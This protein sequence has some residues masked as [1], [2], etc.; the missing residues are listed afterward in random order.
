MERQEV[1]TTGQGTRG[2]GMPEH[3]RVDMLLGEGRQHAGDQ[4]PQYARTHRPTRP[5]EEHVIFLE[6]TEARE[7]AVECGARHQRH[8]TKV[9]SMRF[10]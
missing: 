8:A 5:T 2:E 7:S 1:A 10:V 9:A 6:S 3:V 4:G